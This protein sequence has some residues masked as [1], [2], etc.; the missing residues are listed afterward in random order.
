[1][2]S[3]ENFTKV[4]SI[5]T[6][7]NLHSAKPSNKIMYCHAFGFVN[8]SVLYFSFYNSIQ[9]RTFRWDFNF[10]PIAFLIFF[11]LVNLL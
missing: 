3:A 6:I 11:F 5:K 8:I 7:C 2:S 4:Q 10:L 9:G 1:M